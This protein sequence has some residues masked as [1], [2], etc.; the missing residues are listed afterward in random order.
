[1][2]PCGE[3]NWCCGGGGGVSAIEEAEELRYKAFHRKSEQVNDL[4]VNVL[5]TACANCRNVIE[6]GFENYEMDVEVV[7]LTEL[8]ADQLESTG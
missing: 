7:G 4:G 1:M 6:E 5:V 3:M 8:I 2:T